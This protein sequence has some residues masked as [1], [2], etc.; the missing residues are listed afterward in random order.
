MKKIHDAST[1]IG[2]LENGQLNPAFSAEIG[3]T[4]EKLAF[5]HGH[6]CT[7][8]MGRLHAKA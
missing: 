5:R 8:E 7:D 4:L 1:I 3:Q 2:M 6:R